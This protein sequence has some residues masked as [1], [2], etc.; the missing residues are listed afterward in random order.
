MAQYHFFFSIIVIF[1]TPFKKKL[2]CDVCHGK[3]TQ[4]SGGSGRAGAAS[5]SLGIV[6]KHVPR[7]AGFVNGGTEQSGAKFVLLGTNTSS[8]AKYSVRQVVTG[9]DGQ[10]TCWVQGSPQR[11]AREG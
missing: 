1:L 5:L 10:R 3:A 7:F 9:E 6:R 2:I 11:Q 4:I 8:M